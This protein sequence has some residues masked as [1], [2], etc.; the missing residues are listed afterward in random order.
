MAK[1][2]R[3][4]PVIKKGLNNKGIIAKE[5]LAM[6]KLQPWLDCVAVEKCSTRQ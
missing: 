3:I 1:Y 5:K 6:C 2:R 4:K